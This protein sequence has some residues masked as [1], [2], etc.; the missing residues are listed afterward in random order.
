VDD[1]ADVCWV[2][3]DV[4]EAFRSAEEDCPKFEHEAEKYGKDAMPL[5]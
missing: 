1:V 3:K 4:M 5:K 2:A